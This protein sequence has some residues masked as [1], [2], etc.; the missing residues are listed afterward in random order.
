MRAGC[1]RCSDFSREITLTIGLVATAMVAGSAES[2]DAIAGRQSPSI[3][4]A[5]KPNPL[6]SIDQNRTTVV[7]RV[8]AQWGDALATS[9][10]GLSKEQLQ[11][12]LT[13]LRSDQLLAAS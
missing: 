10:A 7:D 5:V 9:D 4:S 11:S 2:A 6:L 3:T 12:L 1:A 13:G 8:V